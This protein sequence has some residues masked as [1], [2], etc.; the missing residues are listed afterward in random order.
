MKR[1]EREVKQHDSVLSQTDRRDPGL[2]VILPNDRFISGMAFW[3][4]RFKARGNV[5]ITQQARR[6]LHVASAQLYTGYIVLVK[7]PHK[8][9]E[10][11]EKKNGEAPLTHSVLQGHFWSPNLLF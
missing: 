10:G 8:M 11:R 9:L 2:R 3:M 4:E 1:E 6:H 5:Q 7:R